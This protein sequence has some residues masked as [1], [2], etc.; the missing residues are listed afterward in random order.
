MH[1]LIGIILL[2]SL[3][4]FAA[5]IVTFDNNWAH[6]HLFNVVSETPSGL[7]II[8]SIKKMVIE[9]TDIDGVP[10]K[11]FGVPGIFIPNNEG[12]PNLA[13]TGRY[14][15]IPQGAQAVATIIASR[16]EVYQD[17]EITP[18]P[19]IPR[20]TDNS[21]LRYEKNMMIYGRNAHYPETPVTLSKPAKIRGLDVVILGITP[22]QYN[23]VTKELIIYK[24]IKVRVDFI[25]GN[26]RFGE[27][28]LRSRF[29]DP[30]L[31]GHLL[32]YNSL[33][34][35]D[36]YATERVSARDGYEYII[37]VPDDP[38]FEA[39]A[40]TIKLWRKLQG[41]SC[42]VFTLT[43]V[44]G[45][46][47]GAIENFLNNAY[48]TWNPAPVAFLLLSDYPSSG[49][50]YGIISQVWSGEG[51]SC[52]SDNIYADVDGDDLPDMHHARITAQ[53]NADLSIMVNKFL[54]YE[55]TPYTATNFYN[56]PLV[57]VGW[58]TERW[59][60]LCGEVIRGFL[61]NNLGKNPARQYA[62]YSGTP[63]AGGPWSSATNTATVVEYFSNL[64]YIEPTNP[65]DAL[66]WNNG[67]SAGITNAINSGAFIVQHR[68]HGYEEGWGEPAYSNDDLDNLT[69]TMFT[70]VFSTNCC[71][72]N[73]GWENECF[74]EKF[75]RIGY[76][77]L[78][79]NA[80]TEVSYSFVNDT[81][82][83]GVYDGLWPE[84][85][86][87][88]PT[89]DMTGHGN[90]RPC[91]AMTF[92]KYFLQ[93]SSWPFIPEVKPITYHLF[94]HHGDVFT[95]LY[96]EMPQNLTVTHASKLIE[97]V[98][99]FAV[100]ADDSSVIALTVN[101]EIIGVAEGRGMPIDITVLPQIAG[102]TM[103]V[104]ITKAN[105]YRYEAD[106]P[107]VTSTYPY[108]VLTADII[109]DTAGGNGDGFVN[110]GE[111]IDYG[112]WAKN[113][114]TGA[115]LN[116]YGIL[117][118][119]DAYV[120]LT[121]DSSWYGSIPED[122]STVSNPYYRYNVVDNCPNNHTIH[123][124]L[125][126]HDNNDSMWTSYPEA[127][128][129]APVLT[130]QD[131]S[132]VND[133]NG[134]T[135]L[136]PGETADLIV[137]IKNEGGATAVDVTSYLKT[138]APGITINDS[139]SN[140]GSIDPGNTATNSSDPY[141][142]SADTTVA[143]GTM[144]DF[145]IVLFSGVYVDTLEFSLQVG[146]KC[147]Y[148]WNPD[149]TPQSGQNIDSIL[150]ALGYTG[151]YGTTLAPDLALYQAVLV[152]VGM[153]PNNHTIYDDSPEAVALANFLENSGGRVYLEG[154]DVWYY[155]VLVG[156]YDFGPLFGI[157]GIDDGSENLGPVV[158]ESNTFTTGMNF[159]YGGENAY[160][161]HI[162]STNGS[163]RIFH[164]SD[165][166]YYC[167]VAHNPGSYITVG[168]SFELGLLI[169][170]S[171]PSTREVLLDSIMKF[172][173]ISTTPGIEEKEEFT[174]VPL[175]T[176]L[177]ALYPNPGVR[178]F[179]IRYD[180]AYKSMVSLRLYD[181]TGRLVRILAHGVYNPGSYTI[182]WNG[183][184]NMDRT[185]PAGIYFVHLETDDYEKVAK[186][187]LLR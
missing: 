15:A 132:V 152:C 108:I 54:S 110:P 183:R 139:S 133:N 184:D 146:R 112:V 107:I 66:W 82:I 80:A 98:P 9:E 105:Y 111:T 4:C 3:F 73:Y 90:L 65:Y 155:D 157:N 186:A 72:G 175:K 32:N 29:W 50:M 19:N 143:N 116:V 159:D 93:S 149:P 136:D 148:L 23:P 81:Y 42:E 118:E 164:D 126:F 101:G 61:I 172:F 97:G 178:R 38:V 74:T 57:A 35:I 10:M 168:T 26:G 123:F 129:Y 17:V 27:D 119:S 84:F 125:E 150:T 162:D 145:Q 58:Q 138:S 187:I 113:F 131:V 78:G 158:G 163:F 147:Y 46:S 76:G 47:G 130:F 88:Y 180:I 83:W 75:H 109:D 20:D 106:V 51:G 48:N 124:T 114:G 161:D 185:L 99:S 86:P 174:G 128:V 39:W 30:I 6:S 165:D 34:K 85:M 64:G 49:D 18:A 179:T 171:A 68:D 137:T 8:F 55:R 96:S 154:G 2:L 12:A 62:I 59:F 43:E 122:D 176:I 87:D 16:T 36:F 45:G 140:F 100:T 7:E 70:F 156:G 22:F 127:T 14:I 142:V 91:M 24:D 151:D 21:P 13:G 182:V 5:E 166:N 31:Q 41:I 11:T 60:Q 102:D 94:H 67:S 181:V 89:S 135:F 33:P 169:D 95:T 28:R 56:E 44:G 121:T 77:A 92:G 37:I 71:T 134:D 141:A 144:I 117:A 79:V 115:A 153:F 1:R 40:D 103:R 170:G 177:H 63:I 167:G 53:S 104:T 69:N 173:G 160:V 52:I 120:N 25:G